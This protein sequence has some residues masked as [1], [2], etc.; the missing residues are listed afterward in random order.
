MPEGPEVLR[1]G[2]QLSSTIKGRILKSLVPLSGKLSRRMNKV[3]IDQFVTD[4]IVKGKTIFIQL[5][6]GREIVSTLGMSGWWYPTAAKLESVKVYNPGSSEL[7]KAVASSMKHARVQLVVDGIND[8]FYIDPRNFGNMKIITKD[9][10][11]KIRS[12]IGVELLTPNVAVDG[13]AALKA[14]RKQGNREIGAVLLNQDILCG[15]G[16]I[17]RAETLYIARI[18]P[19]KKIG[20]LTDQDLI[21]IIETAVYILNLSYAYEGTLIYPLDLLRPTLWPFL[22]EYSGNSVRG[23]LAYGRSHDM[24]GNE[25][26]RFTLA[27]R[28][29]W[30]VPAI[31]GNP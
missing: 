19:F 3:I 17:Y 31:Q 23:P 2:N 5:A 18:D 9:E 29:M 22:T 4:V 12:R 26:N 14:L 6:D 15:I 25:V 7:I 27:G 8:A 21:R 28:T 16:N 13:V 1:C 24:F 20:D 30:W 11:N 10:A